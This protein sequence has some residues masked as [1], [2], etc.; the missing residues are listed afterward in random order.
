M[1]S[2]T[3]TNAGVRDQ[4]AVVTGGSGSIGRA[5][6]RAFV[7]D[8]ARVTSLDRV[9]PGDAATD[10]DVADEV[11]DVSSLAAVQS[12]VDAVV[13]RE[14]RIDIAVGAAGVAGNTALAELAEP[15]LTEIINVNL[16]GFLNLMR[17]V[18]PHMQRQ[19]FG[20]IVA[21]G[22]VAA[23]VGGVKS[24]VHYVAAKSAV[25]GAVKWA[26]KTYAADGILVN[27]VAPGP[28]MTPMW[29]GLNGGQRVAEAP[30][31]PLGRLGEPADIAEPIVFLC[32]AASNWI[33][34][35]V[36]DINGG[37]YFS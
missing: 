15:E 13:A 23:R 4:V 35:Q 16:V 12:A 9:K 5:V 28:V 8:G 2:P 14:G 34:G 21:L 37:M 7:R 30:G 3:S 29:D 11:I 17:A 24:G 36:I 10:P 1:S 31:V 6:V 18:I 26:A 25:H 22:S 20:K 27:A 33:T 32:G 19:R